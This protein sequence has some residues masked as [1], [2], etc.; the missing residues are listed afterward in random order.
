MQLMLQLIMSA[1]SFLASCSVHNILKEVEIYT[2]IQINACMYI[3]LHVSI[4][5]S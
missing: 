5:E 1:R 2:D 4:G 3:C